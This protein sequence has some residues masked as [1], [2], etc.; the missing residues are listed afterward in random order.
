MDTA[1]LR[2]A[3]RALLDA[4]A[5]VAGSETAPPPGEWNVEEILAHV[6]VI[7]AIT[8]AAVSAVASGSIATYD[9]RTGQDAWTLGRVSAR[10]G[11][12][13]GLRDRIAVQADALCAL[14][15]LSDAELDT[16]VPTLLVSNGDL[17]VDQPVPLRDLLG[18]LTGTELPAHTR[19]ILALAPG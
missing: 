1:P 12:A 17:L 5:E 15:R 18:G 8:I 10:A 14:A 4:A 7:S 3:Y 13:A 9:N 6:S 11:G 19:Q 16:P 2:D